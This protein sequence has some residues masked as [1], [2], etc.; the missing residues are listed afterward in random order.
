[1][2]IKH[3]YILPF[4]VILAGLFM[5]TQGCTKNN[6]PEPLEFAALKPKVGSP[7]YYEALRSYKKSD[8][9]ICFAWWGVSGTPT[10]GP[11]MS[12]RYEGLPDSMDIVSLWGGDPQPG[13]PVWNEMQMVRQKK[14]TRFVRCM[15]GSGVER[16]MKKNDSALF[17]NNVMAAIDNVAKAIA[18]TVSR[19]QIDGF[20]L[21][22]EPNFGDASIFGDQNSSNNVTNDPHTQ[23]LFKALSQYMGPMSGT[24]KI[25]MIDG[26]FDRGIEPYVNYLAQQ[27]YFGSALTFQGLQNRFQQYGAGILPSKKFIVTENMQGFGP[28]GGNFTYNGVNIGSVLGMATWNPTQ[29]RKGGFGAYLMEYDALSKPGQGLYYHLRTG[30]QIQNPAVD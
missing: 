11:D 27:T 13:S 21:D 12:S 17:V 5:F 3:R 18:D 2:N 29:G 9:A 7:E 4:S 25:L 8:H 26:Q 22:Y 10:I 23:R 16:L 6:E 28:S 24:D 20:D 14:G 15:F 30:I 1:M 19:Y